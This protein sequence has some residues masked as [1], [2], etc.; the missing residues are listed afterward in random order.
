[1]ALTF[2]QKM[3][4]KDGS[5]VFYHEGWLQSGG[6]FHI[7]TQIPGLKLESYFQFIAT[8][9]DFNVQEIETYGKILKCEKGK[10]ANAEI[11]R[12]LTENPPPG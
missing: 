8:R 10:L 1:M 7:I 3:I 5:M 6:E 11:T 12:F 9:E 2:E 4:L